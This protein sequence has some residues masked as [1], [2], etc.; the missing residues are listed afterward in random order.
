[1]TFGNKVRQKLVPLALALAMALL[2]PAARPAYADMTQAWA[3][4][5]KGDYPK[6]AGLFRTEAEH[7]DS[8][9]QYM[10]GVMYANRLLGDRDLAS[11]ARWYEKAADQ[12]HP[13]A[14]DALGYL[15]DFG[16]SVP[17]DD[18]KAEELYRSAAEGGSLNGKNNIA[19]QW[20]DQGRSLERALAYAREAAATEPKVGAY[21]DTLGW[22]LY[23]LRRYVDALP[24]LCRAAK[25]DPSSPEIHSHLGDAYWHLGLKENA[26]MQWQQAFELADRPQLLDDEGQDFLYADGATF[27]NALKARLDKGP[28]DGPAPDTADQ[29]GVGQAAGGDCDMPTS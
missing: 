25:L 9:A 12:G 13:D 16:L 8:E 21:Q 5:D 4:Y 6:A 28:N 7:G 19:F 27:R 29:A 18:A 2:I 11:A 15:Y 10:L 24:P 26:Q 23:R 22:A 17:R 3:A 20:A 1:M 14:E